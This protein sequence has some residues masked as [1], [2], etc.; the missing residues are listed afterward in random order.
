[1][2][3]LDPARVRRWRA[4]LLAAGVSPSSVAKAYRLLRAILMTAVDDVIARNPCRIR[5][6]QNE[7]TPERPVLSAQQVL[8]LAAAVPARYVAMVLVAAFGSLRWGE[9]A[10][11]RRRD[12]DLDVGSV[13]VR[14]SLSERSTGELIEGPPKSRAG[15]R[16]VALPRPIVATLAD[17]LDTWTQD[18]PDALVFTGEKGGPLRRSNYNKQTR[19]KDAIAAIG[20]PGLHFHDLRHTGNHL[21]A[22]TGASLRDLMLRMGHDSMRAALIYQHASDTGDRRIADA[23]DAVIEAAA[24]DEQDDGTVAETEPHAA[25]TDRDAGNDAGP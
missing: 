8:Q 1:I 9:A 17:H 5:G 20:V 23:L 3:D 25:D 19:W 14:R 21:A 15:V 22:Q 12:V 16:V 13:H 10:A 7:P 11:L 4:D 18:D 2:G 6:A 24:E